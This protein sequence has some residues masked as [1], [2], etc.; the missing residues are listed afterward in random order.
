MKFSKYLSIPLLRKILAVC[1]LVFTILAATWP[2]IAECV[3]SSYDKYVKGDF[4]AEG[5][6][7]LENRHFW[8][9]MRDMDNFIYIAIFFVVCYVVVA[10][11]PKIIKKFKND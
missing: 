2:L 9:E 6:L 1:T 7:A 11:G 3:H 8:Y 10:F 4:G 5:D